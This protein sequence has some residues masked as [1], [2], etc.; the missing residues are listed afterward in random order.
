MRL[1]IL[2][3]ACALP[4][5]HGHAQQSATGTMPE[6]VVTAARLPQSSDEIVRPVT[7]IS[8]EDIARSG[9]Q[10]VADLLQTLGGVEISRNGGYGQLSGVFIR[11]A[12]SNHTLV[13]V[14]GLRVSSATAGTTAFENIPVN[15]IERIEI[16]PGPASGLYGSDAVGGVIQ[17]FTKGA[18]ATPTIRGSAGSGAYETRSAAAGMTTRTERLA[19]G[20]SA[21][22]F[23]TGGFSATKP[24]IP[25]SQHN[26][27]RDGYRNSNLSASLTQRLGA[28]HEIGASAMRSEGRTWFDS[29]PSTDDVSDERLTTWSVHTRNRITQ[30]WESLL[31]WGEGRDDLSIRGAF[32][33]AF[34]TRQPQ[35]TWQNVVAMGP[36]ALLAGGERLGQRL[37]TNRAFARTSRDVTSWFAGYSGLSGAHAWQVNARHDDNEQFGRHGTGNLAYAY[38]L[39]PILRLRAGGG[40]AFKAPTFNDLYFPGFSNPELRPER[41]RNREAGADYDAAGERAS[42]TYF[43][44]RITDLIVFDAATSKP[45]NVSRARIRAVE[46]AY[47]LRGEAFQGGATL[48]VQRPENELTGRLLQRRA[49]EH[50]TVDAS[51]ERGPW[52]AGVELVASSARFDSANESAASRMHGYAFANLTAEYALARAWRVVARWNNVTDRAYEIAQHYNTPGSNVFVAVQ[53]RPGSQ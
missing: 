10:S 26:P 22:W 35:L 53:Y 23:E 1:Y 42:I 44:N 16:V 36:G 29:G 13:L 15:L 20:L 40:S 9:Q 37:E 43:D 47:R 17:I 24:T 3:A 39:S 6:I 45:Q 7:V 4:A 46:L 51:Y 38:R 14:D 31:Q 30:R 34:D 8:S 27:D 49:R 32:P 48:T 28:G 5:F 41:A 19:F 52:R 50:G 21:G 11:G 33:S 12:N 25:F 2:A 18:G